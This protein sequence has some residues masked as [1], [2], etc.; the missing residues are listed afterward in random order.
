MPFG[1]QGNRLA[2]VHHR[3]KTILLLVM[4]GVDD[5][6][7]DYCKIKSHSLVDDDGEQD[8]SM[9]IKKHLGIIHASKT[10]SIGISIQLNACDK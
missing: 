5:D 1:V 10:K 8:C 3:T 6:S 4:N 2:R 9:E 7:T